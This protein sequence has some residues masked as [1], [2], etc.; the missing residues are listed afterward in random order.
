MDAQLQLA[1]LTE[2]VTALTRRGDERHAENVG[3]MK[4]L[5]FG[6]QSQQQSA[7]FKVQGQ[8]QDL[9][10]KKEAHHRDIQSEQQKAVSAVASEVNALAQSGAA[11]GKVRGYTITPV[12]IGRYKVTIKGQTLEGDGKDVAGWIHAAGDAKEDA[13]GDEQ[14][15]KELRNTRAAYNTERQEGA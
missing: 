14:A 10:A 12:G 15:R 1:R 2:A 4:E 13:A 7:Q 11:S 9:Q 6:M 3:R 5:Q 8:Q